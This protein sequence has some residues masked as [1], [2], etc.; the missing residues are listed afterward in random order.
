VA[1]NVFALSNAPQPAAPP[2]YFVPSSAGVA[3]PAGH[4]S[5]LLTVGTAGL[6]TGQPLA[7]VTVQYHYTNAML[8]DGTGTLQPF[9]GW[10]DDC[11]APLTTT[12]INKA[13]ATVF[14]AF[15]G[16]DLK[17]IPN[18]YPDLA[19]LQINSSPGYASVPSVTLV[20]N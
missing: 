3:V 10:I 18:F 19:R 4:T 7:D 16:C 5:W 2:A 11:E 9:T 6:A 8:N 17:R 20:L 1:T 15:L 12:Y 14:Q 13:G